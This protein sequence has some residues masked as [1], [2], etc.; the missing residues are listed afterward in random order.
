MIKCE[1][2]D[3]SS[4]KERFILSF[5]H[6]SRVA[7]GLPI[8]NGERFLEEALSSLINQTYS[9]LTVIVVDNASTDRTPQII[10]NLQTKFPQINYIRNPQNIGMI[11]NFNKAFQ[12]GKDFDFFMWASHD[13]FYDI[14]YVNKCINALQAHPH[15]VLATAHCVSVNSEKEKV[16][17]DYGVNTVGL[18][19]VDRFYQYRKLLHR[20]G[21]VGN[22]FYGLYKTNYLRGVSPMKQVIASD[23]IPLAEL[24][25]KGEF[26]VVPEDLIYKRAS[27]ASASLQ[28]LRK[29]LNIT[30]PILAYFPYAT[31]EAIFQRII[32][33]SKDLNIA[34]KVISSFLSLYSHIKYTMFRDNYYL[35]KSKLKILLLSLKR[36]KEWK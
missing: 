18:S 24:A 10:K 9:D 20:S 22:L 33:S 13:D 14:N 23:H 7:V 30:N 11:N 32:F 15:A 29:V 1:S 35:G 16:A 26:Y 4:Y 17:I 28:S 21:Y 12:L 34:Q 27:G 31:R 19:P 25:L 6:S 3:F 36:R 8:Y 5:D 2:K